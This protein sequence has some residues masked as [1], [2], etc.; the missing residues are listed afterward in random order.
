MSVTKKRLAYNAKTPEF[1]FWN[2]RND[3]PAGLDETMDQGNGGTLLRHSVDPAEYGAVYNVQDISPEQATKNLEAV[4]RAINGMPDNGGTLLITGALQIY[5]T[6]NNPRRV[7]ND[8]NNPRPIPFCL[9][10]T[11]PQS[12]L[13]QLAADC[14]AV[15]YQS[16]YSVQLSSTTAPFWVEDLT[17]YSK[18]K[19]LLI[20]C[21][22][23][24]VKLSRLIIALCDDTALDGENMD[25]SVIDDIYALQN[26]RDGV[27]L[28]LCR[29]GNWKI[30]SRENEGHGLI[31]DSCNALDL[32][33]YCE[34]NRGYGMKFDNVKLCRLTGW[35]EK[36]NSGGVDGNT[37]QDFPQNSFTLCELE[38]NG[39]MAQD[40]GNFADMDIYSRLNIRLPPRAADST[41]APYVLPLEW[42]PNASGQAIDHGIY[43]WT[44]TADRL[45]FKMLPGGISNQP[46]DI[47]GNWFEV[48][49]N[50]WYACLDSLTLKVGDVIV[51]RATLSMD[52][53]GAEFYKGMSDAKVAAPAWKIT[54]THPSFAEY[55]GGNF[56]Q[57]TIYPDHI[58]MIMPAVADA[59]GMLRMFLYLCPVKLPGSEPPESFYQYVESFK[60]YHLQGP[61]E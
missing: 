46:D 27:N 57:Q 24:Q 21:G 15:H 10:G 59:T 49:K 18:G 22:G 61:A 43:E 31:L 29:M 39:N 14:P 30:T 44:K 52:A 28:R 7:F 17:I 55:F 9:R 34:D 6:I 40:G 51:I 20:D 23:K 58:E 36:N 48:Y 12:E 60:V 11:G 54:S 42:T 41:Y 13:Y 16:N 47:G 1:T 45:E 8:P 4:Y 37:G 35:S 53:G 26:K 25:G 33:A 56:Y 50:G 2:R 19:G 32:W 3:N 38:V 5:G